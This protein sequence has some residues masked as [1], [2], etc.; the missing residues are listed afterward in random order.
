[1]LDFLLKSWLKC[2]N[3]LLQ[4]VDDFRALFATYYWKGDPDDE[5]WSRKN[6]STFCNF[7]LKSWLK[8]RHR[9]LLEMV[10][11]SKKLQVFAKSTIFDHGAFSAKNE[12]TFCN[13]SRTLNILK[14]YPNFFLV[15]W[16]KRR[17]MVV[18]SKKLHSFCKIDFSC[19]FAKWGSFWTFLPKSRPK[20]RNIACSKFLPKRFFLLFPVSQTLQLFA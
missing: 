18:Y 2:W 8:R 9:G 5:T 16:P 20:R 12:A 17:D 13:F 4:V 15:R 11:C 1:M 19:F 3:I 10:V 6:L 14:V 7:L